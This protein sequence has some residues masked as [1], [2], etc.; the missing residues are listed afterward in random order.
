MDD[1]ERLAEMADAIIEGEPVNWDSLDSGDPDE[2]ALA[3]ELQVVAGIAALHRPGPAA[4]AVSGT[5]AADVPTHWGHLRLDAI[6]GRGS[7]GE[8]Y[9]AWDPQLERAVA[10]K[11]LHSGVRGEHVGAT[12]S[13]PRRVVNEGRLLARLRHPH[14]I[15]VYGAETRDGSVGIWMELIRG[16]TLRQWISEH[17]PMSAREAAAVGID[18]A[19]ALAAVHGAGLLHRDVSAG[20]VMREEGGRIVLMDFGAGHDHGAEQA[21]TAANMTGTPVYM[22]PELLQGSP[23]DARTD[24]Y[25]LGVLLFYLVTGRYPVTGRSLAAIRDAHARGQR[26][27]MRD[28]RPEVPPAFVEVVEQAL[29]AAPARR[30]ASAGEFEMAL[31]R[32]LG[33]PPV[34][35]KASWSRQLAI[36]AVLILMVAGLLYFLSFRDATRAAP[37]G[38]GSTV[39]ARKLQVPEGVSVLSNPS[40]DGRYVA[41]MLN[42]TG[43]TAFVDLVTGMIR[44]LPVSLGDSEGYASLTSLSPDASHVAIDWHTGTKG[45]LLLATTDGLGSRVLVDHVRDVHPH[46]WSRDGA[47]ILTHIT[48]ETG[49]EAIALVAAADG[50]VRVLRR[51]SGGTP[52]RMS[53]SPDGRYV[54]Y[55]MPETG[56]PRDRDLMILDAHTGV[57]R[58]LVVAPG[59]DRSPMWTPDGQSV[60][61]LSDRNRILSAW[62]IDVHQGRPSGSPRLVK[63]DIGR[64][65]LRGFTREG[66]LYYE[67]TAGYA[68]VY[69]ADID[70]ADVTPISPRQAISNFYPVWST[71]GRYLA[72]A[73]ERRPDTAA[74]RDLWVYDA[75][76]G[77]ESVLAGHRSFGRPLAWSPDSGQLLAAGPNTQELILI[78]RLTGDTRTIGEEIT[79]A[80]W[81]SEGIVAFAPGRLVLLSAEDFQPM[82]AVTQRPASESVAFT[83]GPDGRSVLEH[84]RDGVLRLQPLATAGGVEWSDVSISRLLRHATSPHT[85]AVAYAATT[86]T[87]PEAMVLKVW[88]NGEARELI[89][90][91]SP[92]RV[93]LVGWSGAD[94]VLVVRRRPASA[95]GVAEPDTLWRVPVDSRAP[96]RTP[97]A[98]EALRDF[99]PHPDGQQWAFNA[100]YKRSEYWALDHLVP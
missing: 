83:L 74:E 65:W 86:A 15:T 34:E 42:Q 76:D 99:S 29:S 12:L 9:R 41:A 1:E 16:R 77:R 82:I 58:P 85:G 47:Y 21:R 24:L 25:A 8:V 2:R 7:Y 17:G 49:S 14:V 27:R 28:A 66:E 94:E 62:L 39:T 59:H 69:I 31:Q 32:T 5:P 84:T 52:E 60:L 78:D 95:G 4:G 80:Y 10:L 37:E 13:D 35:R 61:F 30:F 87:T 26:T 40:A 92:E 51:L 72:Y 3:R 96:I 68:E 71:D 48:E 6:L 70:S 18:L 100:G 44:P 89:R 43:G 93:I 90:V 67:L 45:T 64:V 98:M 79:S 73:S 46:E 50:A 75:V 23:P 97:I 56:S 88:S 33:A 55:D 53:L 38:T 57:Q 11:L 20:N 54:V 81:L 63:D 22:A 19:G 91:S 36:S